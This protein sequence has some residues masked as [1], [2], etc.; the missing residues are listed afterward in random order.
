MYIIEALGYRYLLGD[1]WLPY[2]IGV[3]VV[4]V[5]VSIFFV[6]R[7]PNAPWIAFL[8]SCAVT[9]FLAFWIV[10]LRHGFSGGGEAIFWN[11]LGGAL[12]GPV[13]LPACALVHIIL[14]RDLIQRR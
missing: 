10:G 9:F 3:T 6:R 1:P 14:R 4:T 12:L 5:F 7:L 8:L 13:W 11:A 2:T